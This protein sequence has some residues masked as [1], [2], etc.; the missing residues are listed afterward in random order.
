MTESIPSMVTESKPINSVKARRYWACLMLSF[1]MISIRWW[2]IY[3]VNALGDSVCVTSEYQYGGNEVVPY[4]WRHHT[5]ETL[6]ALLAFCAVV[7]VSLAKGQWCGTMFSLS[8]NMNWC[9]LIK[10]ELLLL[11]YQVKLMTYSLPWDKSYFSIK[12]LKSTLV[13]MCDTFVTATVTQQ[14]HPM[15]HNLCTYL[16]G[17]VLF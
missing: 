2:I 6:P 5:M 10:P 7:G 8:L 1:Q 14:K 12:Y 17:Y 3:H 9:E 4:S 11:G 15:M 16:Y 13:W